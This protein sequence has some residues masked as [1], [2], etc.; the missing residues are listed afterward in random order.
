MAAN[1]FG[2]RRYRLIS[3][4]VFLGVVASYLALFVAIAATSGGRVPPAKNE[5]W[6]VNS[7]GTLVFG[8]LERAETGALTL[9]SHSTL[10]PVPKAIRSSPGNLIPSQV[11]DNKIANLP[12]FPPRTP[13]V[14]A[15]A[16]SDANEPGIGP[17]QIALANQSA[18]IG[19]DITPLPEPATWFAAAL[20]AGAIA[21]LQRRRLSRRL[22]RQTQRGGWVSQFFPTPLFMLFFIGVAGASANS[23]RIGDEFDH[24]ESLT[25]AAPLFSAWSKHL[26]QDMPC[27]KG[28]LPTQGSRRCRPLLTR[29][30]TLMIGK[31]F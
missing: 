17:V 3:D 11:F 8:I 15:T 28:F 25:E 1:E 13:G 20:V 4:R 5:M 14:G 22:T 12:S 19:E 10:S 24:A 29:P 26:F 31:V 7:A 18:F 23:L 16:L 6:K 30:L 9:S 21:W 27:I 2:S